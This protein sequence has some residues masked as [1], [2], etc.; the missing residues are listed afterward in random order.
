MGD[1]VRLVRPEDRAKDAGQTPG[2]RREAALE[3]GRLWS[4]VAYTAPGMVSAW[5]HHG[6]YETSIYLVSGALRME[7]GP[8][9]SR[10]LDAGPGDFLHIPAGAVHR[11]SNP[12]D[13]ESVIVVTRVGQGPVVVNVDGPQ[14]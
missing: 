1:E 10:S 13:E 9:G 6:E 14:G 8:G 7:F 12:V 5:H 11:E 4:G 3:T 2:M